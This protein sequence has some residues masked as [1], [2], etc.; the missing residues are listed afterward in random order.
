MSSD[1]TKKKAE[2]NIESEQKQ[3]AESLAPFQTRLRPGIF[4]RLKNRYSTGDKRTVMIMSHD[5]WSEKL[6][7]RVKEGTLPEDRYLCAEVNRGLVPDSYVLSVDRQYVYT[8]DEMV[9]EV[10][11]EY[12]AASRYYFVN[13]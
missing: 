1:D 10:L 9:E 13:F 12:D 5:G 11:L 7:L 6:G 4:V 3:H 8:V 2:S